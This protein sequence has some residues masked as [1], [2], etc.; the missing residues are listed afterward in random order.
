MSDENGMVTFSWSN[1]TFRA[2]TNGRSGVGLVLNL[3]ASLA[4]SAQNKLNLEKLNE[5]VFA[6][7]GNIREDVLPVML[8]SVPLDRTLQEFLE[9]KGVEVLPD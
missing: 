3:P 4:L 6:G 9:S 2:T 5:S 8:C 7:E 1:M